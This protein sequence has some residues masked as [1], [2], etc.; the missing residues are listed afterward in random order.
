MARYIVGITGASGSIYGVR[1]IE[2]LLL[3]GNEVHVVLT[4]NG[5]KVLSYELEK[6]F[7]EVLAELNSIG[8][9]MIVHNIEDLFAPIASGSFKVDGMVIVPCSMSALGE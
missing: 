9:R 6:G 2:E 4:N 1:V 7:E 8:G 3:A 5:E